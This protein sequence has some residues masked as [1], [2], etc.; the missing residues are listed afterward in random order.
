MNIYANTINVSVFIGIRQEDK[1]CAVGQSGIRSIAWWEKGRYYESTRCQTI[2]Q[3]YYA[4]KQSANNHLQTK[5]ILSLPNTYNVVI[6]F[7][8]IRVDL[9][10]GYCYG[11]IDYCVIIL[12]P[13][14]SKLVSLVV[15]YDSS[16][17]LLIPP[18][19]W[20]IHK[21]TISLYYTPQFEWCLTSSITPTPRDWTCRA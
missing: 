4:Y 3:H 14:P 8:F 15:F 6:N 7:Y 16:S 12:S 18:R 2:R 21:T 9:I 1:K 19:T 5:L 17:S 10:I 20:F 11:I 13:F